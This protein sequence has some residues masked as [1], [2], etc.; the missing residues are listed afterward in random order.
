MIAPSLG[1]ILLA[2]SV[3]QDERT[4]KLTI[5]GIFDHIEIAP[6]SCHADG[7]CVFFSVGNVHG[8]ERLRLQFV[9]LEDDSVLLEREVIVEATPLETTDLT[10]RI[11]SIPI[12]HLGTF[13]WELYHREERIGSARIRVTSR[14]A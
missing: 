6:G 11:N 3:V 12:P 13:A 8:R 1:S 10:V 7:V 4:G 14:A 5:S 9:D 2:D